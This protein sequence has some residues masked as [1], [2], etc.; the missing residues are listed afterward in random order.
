MCPREHGF[1]SERAAE[2]W[3]EGLIA[4]NGVLGAL[5]LGRASEERIILNRAGLFLPFWAPVPTVPTRDHLPELRDLLRRG[6][7]QRAGERVIEI[8]QEHDNAGDRWTDPLVPACELSLRAPARE[9]S[10]YSRSVDF[11]SGL[12]ST[13][14]ASERGRTLRRLFVSRADNAVVLSLTA[15]GGSVDCDIALVQTPPGSPEEAERIREGI[16]PVEMYAS[17]S[18]LSYVS[19]FKRSWP[20]SLRGHVAAARLI[21]T[22]GAAT[23]VGSSV[24][25]RGASEALLIVGISLLTES[26]RWEL[27]AL[28]KALASLEPS[29]ERL[30]ERHR[31]VHRPLFQRVELDLG[32]TEHESTSE[33]LL[34]RADATAPNATLLE[35]QFDAARYAILSC[36]GE[37]P[38]TLQ[39]IWSG[40]Y[41]PPWSS[42]YTHNGN[43]P[44]AIAGALCGNQA[45]CL[46]PFLRYHWARLADYRSNAERHY[47]CR[48]IFVP[49][50][51]SAHGL[52]NHFNATW[53][54]TFWTAGAAW[55]AHF[56]YDY[57]LHTGDML[58][59]RQ[60]AL[61]F[62]QE[63]LQFYEDFLELGSNGKWTFNPSYSP[64][65]APAGSEA[66]AC[67][68][69]TMDMAVTRELCTS[70]IEACAA[71]GGE[72]ATAE[73]CRRM[74]ERLPDYRI[75]A[76]GA[77]AEWLPPELPDNHEHRHLSHLYAL[78]DGMPADIEARP[79]LVSAFRVALERR[80][81][82]RR[83]EGGGIMAFGLAQLGLVAASLGQAA[84]C[85]EVLGWLSAKYF[86]SSL[87]TTHDPGTLFNVD[88]CGGLPALLIHCLVESRPGTIV[89]LK[90]LPPAF[91][92]G[93]LAGATC[94]GRVSVQR[95]A[96]TPE[97]VEAILRSPVAQTLTV[98]LGV[99]ALDAASELTVELAANEPLQLSWSRAPLPA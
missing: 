68:D 39:G 52:N 8:D 83:R 98:R 37:L 28:E 23:V 41:C 67:V 27:P 84:T 36:S 88:I 16:A 72:E 95:L 53:T 79:E 30:L 4:G 70:L 26:A 50:R 17:S 58:F 85:Q 76:E 78:Y 63:A 49:S 3:E 92:R 99:P 51:T 55:A 25:V 57:Y 69:A 97:R 10:E 14:F 89:L 24:Q 19:H 32:G 5:V 9:V 71:L 87:V 91:P 54:M 61:P 35:K 38:P 20:G 77:L 33:Q 81:Q 59:L 22:G 13:A 2:S 1:V 43:L 45:E 31:A 94:R 29:F 75:N 11:E 56:F 93:S 66:Q 44:T 15:P 12:V 18:S 74:L 21:V 7:Y 82:I 65:N 34:L 86:R 47:G 73:R 62:M 90:A 42:D 6:Q 48:G 46:E 80:L 60:R 64:E 40:T 96:W